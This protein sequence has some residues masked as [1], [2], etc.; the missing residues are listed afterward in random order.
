MVFRYADDTVVIA[1]TEIELQQLMDIVVQESEI[2]DL[3]LYCTK[4]FTMVFFNSPIIPACNITV[5]GKRHDKVNRFI[6]LSN[7]FTS[8]GRCEQDVQRGIGIAKSTFITMEKVL[9]S[10]YIDRQLRIRVLLF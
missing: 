10:I 3:Y 2:K 8:D 6:Y 5:H 7:L 4:S 1:E 9:K